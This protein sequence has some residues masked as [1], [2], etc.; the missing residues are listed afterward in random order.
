MVPCYFSVATKGTLAPL[1]D[2]CVYA[3]GWYDLDLSL[4]SGCISYVSISSLM[5]ATLWY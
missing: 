1:L 3:L 2:Y 4:F 5:M